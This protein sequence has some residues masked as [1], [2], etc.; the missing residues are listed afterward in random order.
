MATIRLANGGD[1]TIKLSIDEVK[2]QLSSSPDFV[3]LPGEDGPVLVRPSSV[4][5]IIEDSKRGTAGSRI[6]AAAG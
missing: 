4:I 5:A 6:S 3:E 1:L 2:K